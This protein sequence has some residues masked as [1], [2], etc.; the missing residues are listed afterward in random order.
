[1]HNVEILIFKLSIAKVSHRSGT[2]MQSSWDFAG[3]CLKILDVSR[4]GAVDNCI[5]HRAFF[6][7]NTYGTG[8]QVGSSILF[9]TRSHSFTSET[10]RISLQHKEFVVMD[11]NTDDR[12]VE[13]HLTRNCSSQYEAR[14]NAETK[15]WRINWL[16][17][18]LWWRCCCRWYK[19]DEI[20]SSKVFQWRVDYRL[21]SEVAIL[22]KLCLD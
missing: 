14:R 19:H 18:R 4:T 10:R 16:T 20:V 1:M 22:I 6:I 7:L 2:D 15:Q 9:M 11:S 8:S 12:T 21:N 5:H 13:V 3:Q 17:K